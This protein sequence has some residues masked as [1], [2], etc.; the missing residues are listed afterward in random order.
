MSWTYTLAELAQAVGASV[1]TGNAS[2]S[3]EGGSMDAGLKVP[4]QSF[5]SV[6]TDTRSL[7]PGDVFFALSGENFDGNSFVPQA[8]EKGA[9]AAVCE[10]PVPGGPCIVVDEPLRRL[11]DFAAWHRNRCPA[12]VIAITGSSGKTT[13]KDLTAAVLASRRI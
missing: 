13:A 9:I 8:F 2:H 1:P 10:R 5:S 12:N 6:S 11:Q 4:E 3:S 7:K